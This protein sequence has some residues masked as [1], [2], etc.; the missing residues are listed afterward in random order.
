MCVH[1]TAAP[2]QEAVQRAWVLVE[3]Y[4]NAVTTASAVT[5]AASTKKRS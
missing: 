4:M 2:V 1:D 3:C 5:I